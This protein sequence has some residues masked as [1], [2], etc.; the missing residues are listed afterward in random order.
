MKFLNNYIFN[1]LLLIILIT[2]FL[3]SSCAKA[4]LTVRSPAE[5]NTRKI[6]NIAVGGFEIGRIM[7]KFKT[8]RN[9]VWQTHPVL[10]NDEQQKSISRS[11]RARV[12]NLL[13]ATPYFKV[14][15]SDEFE[16]L[17]NDSAL[18]QLVSVR[19]YKTKNVDAVINGK[20]WLEIERTDG[21]ELSKEGLEYFRPPRSRNSLGLNL[22]VDQVVWWPYKST[23][24]TLGLEIKLTRLLPTEVVATTFETRTYS[25]RIGGRS[26]ESFQQIAES[27]TSVLSASK[28]SKTD[29]I[30]SSVDVLPAFEQ[31]IADMALSIASGFVRRVAVTEKVV[32]YPVAEGS[33]PNAK[34]LIEAG[35]YDLA[36]AQLQQATAE[37]PDPNDLYNLG[38]C[39]EAIGD[40]GLAQNT[41]REA[42]QAE[43]ENL[44]FAQGLGRIE[45]LRREHPQL[46]RQLESR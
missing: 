2:V 27:F 12:I 39:F 6:K 45:R 22:T 25:Q 13:T 16:K 29:N 24:G 17:G 40:F 18:Q 8:E 23:R 20:L 5:I 28:S 31:I 43:P 46:Q 36:I 11:V 32:S 37:N 7:L 42:W 33:F 1:H 4:T 9:G 14:I 3:I 44:L 38:L 41:Y 34:I 21:V 26:G 15:F 10:L 30:E 35:A 19:G